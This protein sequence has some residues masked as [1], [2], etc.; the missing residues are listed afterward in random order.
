MAVEQQAQQLNG[1]SAGYVPG[2]ITPQETIGWTR[3]L[4]K[5]GGRQVIHQLPYEN[6]HA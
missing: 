4:I 6:N 5:A 2:L 3:V 1:S